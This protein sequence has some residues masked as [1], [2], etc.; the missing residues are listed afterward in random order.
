MTNNNNE[1]GNGCARRAV[2]AWKQKQAIEEYQSKY[3]ERFCWCGV[4]TKKALRQI[5]KR[6][7]IKWII[8]V[9]SIVF[10]IVGVI[11]WA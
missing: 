3:K 10:I 5:N 1:Y 2:R 7:I 4:D 9:L 8:L 11:L 6:R